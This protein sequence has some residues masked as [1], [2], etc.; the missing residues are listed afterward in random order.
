MGNRSGALGMRVTGRRSSSSR[1]ASQVT[2]RL[3]LVQPEPESTLPPALSRVNPI[4][5]G[6]TDD[7]RPQDVAVTSSL[8]SRFSQKDD[9]PPPEPPA[10]EIL[11]VPKFK[12]AAE[13]EARRKLR[14]LA[15]RGQT[16]ANPK[17]TSDVNKYLNPE[18]SSSDDDDGILDDDNDDEFDII[19]RG[20]DMDEGDEFDPYALPCAP[21][22]RYLNSRVVTL[23]L[24]V[25]LAPA[26]TVRQT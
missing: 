11:F 18:I 7:P 14:M 17:T 20:D 5:S 22:L 6:D 21:F 1:R 2:G 26:L 10:K 4:T 15:R 23:P 13:M 12:G 19:Q 24:H 16:S 3:T 9:P 8:A 25:R